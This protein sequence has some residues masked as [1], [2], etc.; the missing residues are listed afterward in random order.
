M[1]QITLVGFNKQPFN[2]KK[3][4]ILQSNFCNK[5]QKLKGHNNLS[6]CILMFFFLCLKKNLYFDINNSSGFYTFSM[7]FITFFSSCYNN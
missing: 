3:S 7:G 6:L 5:K 4:K 2:S 1:S